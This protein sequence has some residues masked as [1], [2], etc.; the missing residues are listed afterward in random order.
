M[1]EPIKNCAT[2]GHARWQVGGLMSNPNKGQCSAPLLIDKS[3]LPKCVLIERHSIDREPPFHAS[4]PMC[5]TNCP[6]WGPVGLDKDRIQLD[7]KD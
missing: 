1:D 2:C 7:Q 4:I 6:A 5:G 3:T